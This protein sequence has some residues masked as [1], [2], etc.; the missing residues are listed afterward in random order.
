MT[1]FDD[2]GRPSRR[3]QRK[4]AVECHDSSGVWTLL[5]REGDMSPLPTS[6]QPKVA[7]FEPWPDLAKA[8]PAGITESG[9]YDLT[10]HSFGLGQRGNGLFASAPGNRRSREPSPLT[11]CLSPTSAKIT[12]RSSALAPAEVAGRDSRPVHPESDFQHALRASGHFSP[13][14]GTKGTLAPCLGKDLVPGTA[15]GLVSEYGFTRRGTSPMNRCR[16]PVKDCLQTDAQPGESAE[17]AGKHYTLEDNIPGGLGRRGSLHRQDSQRAR[18]CLQHPPGWQGPRPGDSADV[19]PGPRKGPRAGRSSY[20]VG[21]DV[22]DKA[23][24]LAKEEAETGLVR[25]YGHRSADSSLTEQVLRPEDQ[26]R[27]EA[28]IKA[29]QDGQM[30]RRGMY[31]RGGRR[32]RDSSQTADLLQGGLPPAGMSTSRSRAPS[33]GSCCSQRSRAQSLDTARATVL[34]TDNGWRGSEKYGLCEGS[35]RSMTKQIVHT[36]SDYW[37]PWLLQHEKELH[38]TRAREDVNPGRLAGKAEVVPPPLQVPSNGLGLQ[39]AGGS[40]ADVGLRLRRL[41]N[42]RAALDAA[43]RPSQEPD[44][45]ALWSSHKMASQ[46]FR[47]PSS[48]AHSAYRRPSA[49]TRSRSLDSSLQASAR[50]QTSWEQVVSEV[51]KSPNGSSTPA[52]RE[53]LRGPFTEERFE[54][55][56]CHSAADATFEKSLEKGAAPLGEAEANTPSAREIL[57]A[58][59]LQRQRSL[60]S[61]REAP[62]TGR[63]SKGQIS[64]RR[65]RST[66]R[67][68]SPRVSL[69]PEA[70]QQRSQ[71]RFRN[72]SPRQ[73]SEE[74]FLLEPIEAAGKATHYD[75]SHLPSPQER[76]AARPPSRTRD[77]ATKVPE[78]I[79]TSI[80]TSSSNHYAASRRDAASLRPSREGPSMFPRSL[81]PPPISTALAT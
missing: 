24:N 35:R 78:A 54:K 55:G 47:S 16:A 30:L 22:K 12:E 56:H 64:S 33:E 39:L 62:G 29:A 77:L 71:S 25:R 1:V 23:A 21:P 75:N 73:L 8:A 28:E 31:R 43:G 68:A 70:T 49:R 57:D 19:S 50:A 18:I 41:R 11:F 32:G 4:H 27:E 6:R 2:V 60:P 67:S 53:S 59:V 37:A 48:E 7:P 44:G 46:P 26:R 76:A 17:S 9:F 36:T 13:Q 45:S 20:E 72:V 34:P 40:T 80:K 5:G 61:S 52:G 63:S 42:G 15:A 58:F 10:H 65:Q 3:T 66:S 14:R 38:E 74:T 79:P 81:S 69:P 51:Q